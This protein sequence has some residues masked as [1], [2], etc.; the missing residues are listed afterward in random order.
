MAIGTQKTIDLALYWQIFYRRR[1]IILL[2]IIISLV[3]G[4]VYIFASS[5]EFESKAIIRIGDKRRIASRYVESIVPGARGI[6]AASILRREILSYENVER[7]IE[8][9]DLRHDAS[10]SELKEKAKKIQSKY[11]SI[12]LDEIIDILLVDQLRNDFE[13]K[14]N[15]NQFIE[16]RGRG[17]SPEK[18]Y[19]LVKTLADIFMESTLKEELSL[20][21]SSEQFGSDQ[22]EIYRGKLE[23]AEKELE[24]YKQQL[25][26]A[27]TEDP[28][29]L[30]RK[31]SQADS[32]ISS[33]DVSIKSKKEELNR[34]TAQL[35]PFV[36]KIE[37]A[38]SEQA[39]KIKKEL[40]NNIQKLSRLSMR[41]SWR[42]GEIIRLNQDIKRLSKQLKLL[43]QESVKRKYGHL[44]ARQLT[45]LIKKQILLYDLDILLN[46][47]NEM[48]SIKREYQQEL[49]KKPAI[50]LTL[51]RLEQEVESYRAIYNLFLQQ[52]RGSEIEQAI[53]RREASYKMKII[54]P[55]QK[56]LSPIKPNKK[57]IMGLSLF[58]G[59]ALGFGLVFGLEYIDRSYKDVEDIE[60]D[61][62]IRVLGIVPKLEYLTPQIHRGRGFAFGIAASALF[63]IILFFLMWKFGIHSF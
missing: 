55:A 11:P 12:K 39:K 53:Q 46:K 28:V 43:I 52:A 57:R 16:I 31:I 1:F 5:P 2:P 63:L 24:R 50:N 38:E 40:L 30:N 6:E 4:G 29:T 32:L 56:P 60:R 8:T 3:L 62:K 20:I 7:L 34:V 47:K 15:S 45:A 35:D 27:E 49:E 22:L 48:L 37:I 51:N 59:L 44:P 10:Y 61:L 33:Y 19:L 9:L 21:R 54:E 58:I 41:L 26:V 14:V 17:R 23:Q 36:A 42:S 18:T 25:A 13:I